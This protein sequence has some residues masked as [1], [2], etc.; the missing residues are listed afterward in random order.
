MPSRSLKHQAPYFR[1]YGNKQPE[2]QSLRIFGIA[3]Y[4]YLRPY[5]VH[6]FQPRTTQCVFLGYSSGYKGVLCY[7][8]ANDKF[9]ISRHVI[10]DESIWPFKSLLLSSKT[11]VSESQVAM[12]PI[13]FPLPLREVTPRATTVTPIAPSTSSSTSASLVAQPLGGSD[14]VLVPEV[15]HPLLG[16][17]HLPILPPLEHSSS[18]TSSSASLPISPIN[19]HPMH[20]RLRDGIVQKKQFPDY[21]GYYTCLNVHI[22][23]DEPASYKVASFSPQWKQ[24]MQEEIDALHMQGTWSLV[25][26]P[27]NK[28]IVGSKWIY[29]IK[30]NS[31]G[32]IARHKARLVAQGFSQEQGLDFSETFG[33]VVR[34]NTVRLIL[35]RVAM[36]K[37]QLRQLDVKNAF[38][39]GKLEEEVFADPHYPDFVCKLK[40]S[41]YGLKQAPRAWNAKFTGYLPAIGFQASQS[42]PSLFVRHSDSEVVILLLYVDDI[43]LTGSNEKMVQL[44]IDELSSVFEIKDLGK[45]KFFLGLQVSYASNSDIFVNQSKYA[46]ELLHKAGMHSCRSCSTPCKPHTQVLKEYGEVLTDPTLFRSIVGALQYLTFTRPDLTY[47]INSVCQYMNQPTDLHWHLVKRILIYVQGT[48]E[49]GL[50]FTAGDMHLSAYN[51]ADWAGDINTRRSTIGFV[52]FLGS[53][54]ISLQSKK[55]GSVSRSSTEAEYRALANTTANLAWIQQVLKD[56]KLYLPDPPVAYYDNLSTLALSSNP[57]YHSIIKHLDIDFHFVRERVQKKDLLVQYVSTDEQLVDVFTKGLHGPIF[58]QHCAHLRLRELP[59]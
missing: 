8:I 46:K 34:H 47:S 26:N 3:V 31:D 43:I 14:S 42:D 33:P 4:P 32:F 16:D 10:H 29:K 45:L 49:Y 1:L 12:P 30:R 21:V 5:N 53:N 19:T 13:L 25:P 23:L 58:S 38:L 52:I 9:V 40:K 54:L 39:H 2:L 6:K 56:L 35:S 57:V 50:S 27:G 20:T 37:W 55:Q 11:V 36:N 48:L 44:V 24:A 17:H 51:D 15:H 22:E 59:K 41:L 7:D 28:N 18:G